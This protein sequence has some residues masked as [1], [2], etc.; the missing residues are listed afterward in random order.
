M[1]ELPQFIKQINAK[2]GAELGV[3]AGRSIKRIL[4][5]NK[6][7]SMIGLDLWEIIPGKAYKDNVLNEQKCRKV[8]KK[9]G[10]RAILY[11]G[12][13]NKIAKEVKNSSLDFV[14]YDLYNFRTSSVSLHDEIIGNWI[15]KL[16]PGGYFI[17]RD[18][19]NDDIRGVIEKRGFKIEIC[20]VNGK[21][22]ER[23]KFFK[24]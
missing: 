18:F 7:L 22:S 10:N 15:E 3:K 5:K 6:Q 4:Q 13:A 9:F 21:I 14:F 20:V 24:V 23:L 11:K 12:D 16:K 8:L 1:F 19:H 17:G 2:N